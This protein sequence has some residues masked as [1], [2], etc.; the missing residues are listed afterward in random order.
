MK[1]IVL[2]GASGFVGRQIAKAL[3]ARGH[4][5]KLVLRPGGVERSGLARNGIEVIETGDLFAEGEDWWTS[6]LAGV[7]AV[8]HAAWYVEPGKYLD[9]PVNIDCA[10][11][12]LALAGGA[13]RAGVT[14]FIGIG[15]CFEYRLPN[16]EITEAA[17]LG[18]VTLYAAAKLAL[19]RML[20]RRFAE[21]DTVLTWARLFY[22]FGEG[23]HPARL[24]PTLNRK[25]AAGEPMMLSSGDKIRD[26][27]DV[28]EAGR[29]I[30]TLAET[31]QVGVANICSGRPVTIRQVAEEIADRYG[32]RDLLE[33]GVATVHPRDPEAVAGVCNVRS[34]LQ[35]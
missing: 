30:A 32:R 10:I 18:P 7:D 15:T 9:S 19:Y 6:R 4:R 1:T 3:M 35:G 25:L 34:G 17:E 24:F 2:T 12:S 22:L 23:E 28:A 16:A 8:I 14:Q 29:L 13:I 31:G 5:L 11:G 21:S 33:F 26:F 20:E 27:L